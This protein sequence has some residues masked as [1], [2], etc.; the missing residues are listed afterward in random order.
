[1]S[2]R[3][4]AAVPRDSNILARPEDRVVALLERLVAGVDTLVTELRAAHTHP[5]PLLDRHE[6]T[7]LLSVDPRTLRRL[8]LAGEIPRAVQIG[9]A[10]RWKRAEIDA[11]LAEKRR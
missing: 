3:S 1:M 6:M 7:T 10:K 9:G 2:R 8:E 4:D 5:P 11:W